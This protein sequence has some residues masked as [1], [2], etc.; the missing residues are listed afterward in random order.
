MKL[1]PQSLQAHDLLAT[2]YLQV[3]KN[4]LAIQ[5]C[6]AALRIDPNDQ[7]ALYHLILALRKTDKKDEISAL[8]KRLMNARQT[9]AQQRTKQPKKY[10]LVEQGRVAAQE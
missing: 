2:T 5:Q 10:L 7:Q 4:D 8:V 9:E 1:D 6:Q 3:G